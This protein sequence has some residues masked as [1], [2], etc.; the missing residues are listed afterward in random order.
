MYSDPIRIHAQDG[1]AIDSYGH[2]A[3]YAFHN[4]SAG[5]T[6]WLQGDDARRFRS[7]LLIVH[8]G[9]KTPR[10]RPP[11]AWL[12]D[13]GGWGDASDPSDPE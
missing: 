2:G 6:T 1:F 10:N 5:R 12:W 9:W 8:Y 7:D 3:T 11:L 13:E 4:L